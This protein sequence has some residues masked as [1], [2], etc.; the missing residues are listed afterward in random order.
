ML[1]CRVFKIQAII[2]YWKPHYNHQMRDTKTGIQTTKHFATLCSKE[3]NILSTAFP[4]LGQRPAVSSKHPW[5]GWYETTSSHL[6]CC[7]PSGCSIPS[8][9]PSS[10]CHMTGCR[11]SHRCPPPT[12]ARPQWDVADIGAW[13]GPVSPA[14]N[15]I[16]QHPYKTVYSISLVV[17]TNH[18]NR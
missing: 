16:S 11:S 9:A 14:H 3:H 12:A 10:R 1:I 5:Q 8:P 4:G 15:A 13:D 7:S 17:S 2:T 6:G 18:K